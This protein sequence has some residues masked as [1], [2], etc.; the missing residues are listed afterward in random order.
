MKHPTTS[1]TAFTSIAE[2]MHRSVTI[3]RK[4]NCGVNS[5]H[6]ISREI[7]PGFIPFALGGECEG[8]GHSRE[9]ICIYGL[10]LQLIMTSK[11]RPCHYPLASPPIPNVSIQLE[12]SQNDRNHFI[13]SRMINILGKTVWAIKMMEICHFMQIDMLVIHSSVTSFWQEMPDIFIGKFLDPW[14]LIFYSPDSLS[15]HLATHPVSA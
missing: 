1:T 6:D 13:V 15:F 14:A 3:A 7:I 8:V 11:V 5:V 4:R 9:F 12:F 2:I 10:F